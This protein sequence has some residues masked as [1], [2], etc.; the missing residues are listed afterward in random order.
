MVGMGRGIRYPYSYYKCKLTCSDDKGEVVKETISDE[1]NEQ[2]KWWLY[3][4]SYNNHRY[5]IKVY[6]FKKRAKAFDV[7][8]V[9]G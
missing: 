8:L 5:T 1:R 4:Y 3:V 6:A 9:N 7:A 2:E